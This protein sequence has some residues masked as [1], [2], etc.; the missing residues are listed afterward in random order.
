[1]SAAAEPAIEGSNLIKSP[2]FENEHWH[3]TRWD[4]AGSDKNE[5]TV[6]GERVL[7]LYVSDHKKWWGSA[8]QEVELERGKTY[9]VSAHIAAPRG[10]KVG[11][12][13]EMKDPDGTVIYK[14]VVERDGNDW[15]GSFQ[16][17]G[18]YISIGQEVKK[19]VLRV[20]FDTSY[21]K[22]DGYAKVDLVE[23]HAI[24]NPDAVNNVDRI[25]PFTGNVSLSLRGPTR[26]SQLLLIGDNAIDNGAHYYGDSLFNARRHFGGLGV[27]WPK[28][29]ANQY[30]PESLGAV[31]RLTAAMKDDP[32]MSPEAMDRMMSEQVSL[33]KDFAATAFN[34]SLTK[35]LGVTDLKVTGPWTHYWDKHEEPAHFAQS[36]WGEL[37]SLTAE[38]YYLAKGWGITQLA[39]L[40]EPDG[41]NWRGHWDLYQEMML[42][43]TKAQRLGTQLAGKEAT[44]WGPTLAG[45]GM[46]ELLERGDEWIDVFSWQQ[47]NGGMYI[48]QGEQAREAIEK[49]DSDGKFEPIAITEWDT[50]LLNSI[51]TRDQVGYGIIKIQ[52]QINFVRSGAYGDFRFIFNELLP[53]DHSTGTAAKAHRAYY[54][55][56]LANRAIATP[57]EIVPFTIEGAAYGL[58]AFVTKGP[59]NLYVLFIN[60]LEKRRTAM[61]IDVGTLGPSQATGIRREFSKK[62]NDAIVEK[63]SVVDGKLTIPVLPEQSV[64]LI[65][66][67]HTKPEVIQAPFVHR[68]FGTESGNELW[69]KNEPYVDAYTVERKIG[70]GDWAILAKGCTEAGYL[71]QEAPRD[72]NCLYRVTAEVGGSL[73]KTSD[74]VGPLRPLDSTQGFPFRDDFE[75]AKKISSQWTLVSGRWSITDH[76]DKRHLSPQ[77]CETSVAVVGDETWSDYTVRTNV[78]FS[79]HAKE[80]VVIGLITRYQDQDNYYLVKLDNRERKVSLIKRRNGRETTL[81]SSQ[82][83]GQKTYKDWRLDQK[84]AGGYASFMGYDITIDSVGSSFHVKVTSVEPVDRLE[85]DAEDN[86]DPIL[87]GQAGFFTQGSEARKACFQGITVDQVIRKD[88]TDDLAMWK[89]DGKSWSVDAEGIL[90]NSE[91]ST[92]YDVARLGDAKLRDSHALSRVRIKDETGQAALFLRYNGPDDHIRYELDA[93][94]DQIRL[95]ARVAGKDT[96]LHEE[97]RSIE[98][99]RFYSLL[100]KLDRNLCLAYFD[101]YPLAEPMLF[102][103]DLRPGPI[104]VGVRG[105]SAS[106]DQVKINY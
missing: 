105:S 29:V 38:A 22:E 39:P 87:A 81:A 85:F 7:H 48:E 100:I 70:D 11:L 64:S 2:G 1:M 9:R 66:I 36:V 89:I 42:R 51:D 62:H 12:G 32:A 69:W 35:R 30:K 52:S 78:M 84:H 34:L 103:P 67:P 17:L 5:A 74:P 55:L 58:S 93:N 86:E 92:E 15:N 18:T 16:K 83:R 25:E 24:S 33:H 101:G 31:D 73:G 19:P 94:S 54:A 20:H 65:V 45:F 77:A 44:I 23:I 50:T 104:A 59:N 37:P 40:N 98:A 57:R 96:V 53:V 75:H 46:F 4:I 71:D 88:A 102:A 41:K 91:A 3:W 6:D 72:Q 26:P 61:T 49:Y 8:F 68:A 90:H 10:C 106:F 76:Y 43:S 47:Y 14:R 13:L 27:E 95:I 97:N 82:M 63:I 21:K 79:D 60:S 56:R 99:G 28:S 80:D